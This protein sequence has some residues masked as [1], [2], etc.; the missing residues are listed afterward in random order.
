MRLTRRYRFSASHRL[1]SHLLSEGENQRIYGKCNH[2]FGHGHDYVL[3]VSVA[4]PLDR[5][6][7]R[8]VDLD[9]LDNLVALEVIQPF[10]HKNL[11]TEVDAFREIVPTTENL[12]SEIHSRLIH[13]WTAVFGSAGPELDRI[14]IEET[15][16]NYIELA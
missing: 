8:I 13:R 12:A 3:E 10:E 2:P 11:N 5:A 6:T 16:R 14:R 1:H 15:K 7:G 4:G 9:T